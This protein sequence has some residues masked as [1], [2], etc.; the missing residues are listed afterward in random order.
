MDFWEVVRSNYAHMEASPQSVSSPARTLVFAKAG[1]RLF[2]NSRE[3]VCRYVTEQIERSSVSQTEDS[4]GGDDIRA[5]EP[6][7]RQ[8]VS[9][10]RIG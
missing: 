2:L 5:Y 7:K 9:G 6:L 4:W 10:G 3:A 8:R 1:L